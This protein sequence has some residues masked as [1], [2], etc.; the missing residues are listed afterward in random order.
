MKRID[1]WISI[2]TLRIPTPPGRDK[3]KRSFLTNDGWIGWQALAPLGAS[4]VCFNF[5]NRCCGRERFL[6]WGFFFFLFL[7]RYVQWS[8]PSESGVWNLKIFYELL[9]RFATSSGYM[10]EVVTNGS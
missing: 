9:R 8:D 7:P 10:A 5:L 2:S 3:K 1:E 6:F 4:G